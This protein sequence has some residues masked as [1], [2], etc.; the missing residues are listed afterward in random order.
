MLPQNVRR[1]YAVIGHPFSSLP[2]YNKVR[3]LYRPFVHVGPG[4]M[5]HLQQN[6]QENDVHPSDV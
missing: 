5:S 3:I 1:I 4:T 6:S 2:P